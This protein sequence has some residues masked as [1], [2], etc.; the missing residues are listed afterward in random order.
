M[1]TTF[2]IP[3]KMKLIYLL[4][5]I[6]SS[7]Y[8]C[9]F[10]S[11]AHQTK[12]TMMSTL[13]FSTDTLKVM[14]FPWHQSKRRYKTLL[15]LSLLSMTCVQIHVLCTQAHSPILTN[16]P[17]LTVKKAVLTPFYFNPAVVISK[18][19]SNNSLLCHWD[20]SC[21]LCGKILRLQRRWNIDPA[22]PRKS[23]RNWR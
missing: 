13:I 9:F 2:S 17:I 1:C 3:F 21:K 20:P 8:T 11:Q 18:N 14:S 7:H 16:V 22:R 23:S 10:Q 15:V 6:S 4:T 5:Q 12:S 19:L